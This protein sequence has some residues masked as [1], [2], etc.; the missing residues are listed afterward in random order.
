MKKIYLWAVTKVARAFSLGA[1][2]VKIMTAKK[3][4]EK[5]KTELNKLHYNIMIYYKRMYESSYILNCGEWHEDG[6]VQIYELSYIHLY[7]VY[8][9]YGDITNSQSGQHPADLI[10]QLVEYCAGIAEAMGSNP[11]QAWIFPRL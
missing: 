3:K 2:M 10:A 5:T 7:S 9:F 6:V 4:I 8:T 1:V 11:V